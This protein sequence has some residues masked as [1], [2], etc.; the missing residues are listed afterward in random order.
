VF[1]ESL[2]R[3]RAREAR[4]RRNAEKLEAALNMHDAAL[5]SLRV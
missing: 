2:E 1:A 3:I 5:E 4:D